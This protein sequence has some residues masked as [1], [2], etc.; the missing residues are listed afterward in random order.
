M[1]E[2]RAKLEALG[3]EGLRLLRGPEAVKRR[4]VGRRRKKASA[5]AQAAWKAQGRY[6]G[7]VRQKSGGTNGRAPAALEVAT[8][9]YASTGPDLGAVQLW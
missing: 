1:A 7:T 9:P 5:K 3:G 6:L 8:S 4:P 2:I